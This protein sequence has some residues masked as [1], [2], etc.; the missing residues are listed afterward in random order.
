MKKPTRIIL[1]SDPG[2]DDSLAIILAL[3]SPEIILEGITIVHGNCSVEQGTRNALNVLKLTGLSEIPVF[4]GYGVPLIKAPLFAPETHGPAGLGYAELPDAEQAPQNRHAVEYLID[5]FHQSPGEI[6]LVAI[7]PLTNIAG[8]IRLDPTISEKVKEIFIMGG[9]IKHGGN[10]T[11]LAEFNVFADPHAAHIVFQSGIPITLTPLDVTYQCLLTADDV[12]SIQEQDSR[13]A[14]FIAESTRFYME[15]HDSYQGI[16]GC[17]INDPLTL[18]LVY[19]PEL[20]Q[21]QDLFVG[22]DYSPGPGLGKTYAD[23]YEMKK[24]PPNMRV[25]MEV[26][27]RD[28]ID[29]F[30]ER[31]KRYLDQEGGEPK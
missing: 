12:H 20:C 6:T 5:S 22:V 21:Y 24:E 16:K 11:P 17:I 1:D 27:G 4:Q 28:F 9:A 30:V 2:I 10:T 7:G 14:D 13:I 23:F 31:V 19:A 29:L 18:A 25:A 26:N 15:F 8:A 3:A